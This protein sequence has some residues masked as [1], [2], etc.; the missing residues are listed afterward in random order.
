MKEIRVNRN[1][2]GQRFDKLLAKYL[3]EAPSSFIYKMLRKKNILLNDSK[4]EGREILREGDDIKIYLSDATY[5]KFSK[6]ATNEIAVGACCT[7][8]KI[9]RLR[10]VFED[11]NIIIINKPAG[12]LSQKA[13]PDDISAVDLITE[14]LLQNGSLT[15]HDLISFRP[16]ICS[17]LDRNT[18]GLIAAGKSLCGLQELNR[19]IKNRVINKYYHCMIAG[20]IDT[21]TSLSGYLKKDSR[22]NKVVFSDEPFEDSLFVETEYEPLMKGADRQLLKVHLITGRTHQIRAHLAFAGYPVI[23]DTKYGRRDINER[24]RREYGVKYQLLHAYELSIPE[25]AGPLSYLSGRRFTAPEPDIFR[26]LELDMTNLH[27]RRK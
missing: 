2:A 10:V 26:L 23:G 24:Y 11:E 15:E 22:T 4:A 14:H 8:S 18:S 21:Y 20:S 5:E 6:A 7:A 16:G 1:E 12:M 17:R 13:H 25:I 27:H 9:S 19:L 3:R